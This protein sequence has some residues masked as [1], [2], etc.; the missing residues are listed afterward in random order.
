MGGCER[1]KSGLNH[2]LC[3]LPEAVVFGIK[4]QGATELVGLNSEQ[5]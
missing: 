2:C 5:K 4:E 1:Q 3:I